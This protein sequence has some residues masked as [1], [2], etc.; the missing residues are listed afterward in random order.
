MVVSVWE[1]AHQV[2]SYVARWRNEACNSAL[3]LG[4]VSRLPDGID[5]IQGQYIVP[6]WLSIRPPKILCERF[7]WLNTPSL[8]RTASVMRY[9][10][11]V[12]DAGYD[13]AFRLERSDGGL[14]PGSG[15]SD[16]D[17]YLS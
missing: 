17:F 2:V 1:S 5:G 16:V 15:T 3:P 13:K 10:C 7:L 11:D 12:P 4:T 8:T 6:F 9:W 14:P